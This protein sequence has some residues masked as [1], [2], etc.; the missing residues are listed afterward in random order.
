MSTIFLVGRST[1]DDK[2]LE[3]RLKENMKEDVDKI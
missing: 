2:N 1:L 3:R